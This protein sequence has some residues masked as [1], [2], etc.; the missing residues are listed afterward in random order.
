L[1]RLTP[2]L[3]FGIAFALYAATMSHVHWGDTPGYLD[4]VRAGRW[5]HPSHL[6][7]RWLVG[8]A[9]G[10]VHAR[11][12]TVSPYLPAVL[13]AGTGAGALGVALFHA[14]LRRLTGAEAVPFV[15]A[16]G[17]MVTA[18]WWVEA[19]TFEV[20]LLPVVVLLLAAHATV[21][22]TTSPCPLRAAALV[23]LL[24]GVAAGFHIIATGAVLAWAGALA[25]QSR[26]PRVRIAMLVA[27]AATAGIVVTALYAG[28]T[29]WRVY[30]GRP[31]APDRSVWS[32]AILPTNAADAP[33]YAHP[34][35]IRLDLLAGARCAVADVAGLPGGGPALLTAAAAALALATV[36][37]WPELWRRHRGLALVPALWTLGML[38]L[39]LRVEPANL[40]YFVGPVAALALHAGLVGD[41]LV[42]RAGGARGAVLAVLAAGLAFAA[43]IG[44]ADLAE[45]ERWH[46]SP[47]GDH[48]SRKRLSADAPPTLF[49][50]WGHEIPPER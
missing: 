37:A 30:G 3:T 40:E 32:V 26:P 39:I 5:F 18:C 23:G 47:T 33:I 16:L 12:P 21:T 36:L 14:L 15:A 22:A 44:R 17:L 20:H 13:V 48:V 31:L 7:P 25:W 19:G 43:T 4:D 8:W 50:G 29:A 42:H 10:A 9:V 35:A 6:L 49:D 28:A 41:A 46:T 11:W 2:L 45:V 27:Y 24:Q 1:K 34:D 38:P